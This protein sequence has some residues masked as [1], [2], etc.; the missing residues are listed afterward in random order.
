MTLSN[1]IKSSLLQLLL[2]DE[3]L[4][5]QEFV[6]LLLQKELR[7]VVARINHVQLLIDYKNRQRIELLTNLEK[8][9]G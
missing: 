8:D 7:D 4:S 9:L 3:E 6:L 1:R 2:L 5:D